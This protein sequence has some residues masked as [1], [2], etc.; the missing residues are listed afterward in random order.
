[1]NQSATSSE[2]SSALRT[3]YGLYLKNIRQLSNSSVNHYYDALN[4]ISR[5]LKEKGL[6]KKDIYEIT[7]LDTLETLKQILLSDPDFVD[8]NKRGDGMY[9]AGLNHYLRF[10]SGEKFSAIHEEINKL[11]VKLAPKPAT[12]V[13]HSVQ[14]RSDILRRQVLELA[15]YSCELDNGHQTFIAERTNKPY[16]EGHHIIPMNLQAGYN[17][18]LDV[19]ANIICLCPTCHRKI[20]LGKHKDRADMAEQIFCNRSD[21]LENS[22]IIL[23]KDAFIKV[24]AGENI[25]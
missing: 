2:N 6:V 19:Y 1:M 16:M 20:H 7:D 11:D 21:R 3:Y 5:R 8:L 17:V 22:G 24:V 13:T 9:S 4:N 18:S 15:N 10:A 14:R 23:T 12:I 25:I